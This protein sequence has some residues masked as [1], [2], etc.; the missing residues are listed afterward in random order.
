[1]LRQVCAHLR[2]PLY[3]TIRCSYRGFASERLRPKLFG[4]NGKLASAI[5]DR[6]KEENKIVEIGSE[7]QKFSDTYEQDEDFQLDLLSP[8][9]RGDQFKQ[10]LDQAFPQLN[11]ESSQAKDLI[12]E[13]VQSKQAH[14]LKP[15]LK[16][17]EI[18]RQWDQREVPATVIS[19]QPL[20]EQQLDRLKEVLTKRIEE[21]DK[22]VL[23]QEVDPDLLGGLKVQVGD[24]AIDLSVASRMQEID[25]VLRANR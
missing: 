1:M 7:L 22:L 10:I 3:S 4:S 17:Y 15:I 5:F 2:A 9:I 25:N 20:T 18:L 8:L 23:K 6:A 16:D 19:A 24:S 13:L 21:G 11:I 14:K 12:T